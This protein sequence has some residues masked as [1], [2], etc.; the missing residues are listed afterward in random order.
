MHRNL[1][2]EGERG[3]RAWPAEWQEWVWQSWIWLLAGWLASLFSPSCHVGGLITMV[4]YPNLQWWFKTLR[5]VLLLN[6][7]HYFGVFWLLVF[8]ILKISSTS[9]KQPRRTKLWFPNVLSGTLFF[10]IKL[11]SEAQLV[12]R[13]ICTRGWRWSGGWWVCPCRVWTG[14]GHLL[15]HCRLP[16]CL[17]S[18]RGA[19]FPQAFSRFDSLGSCDPGR[20]P[21]S[22]G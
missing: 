3:R 4:L 21:V 8:V 5:I 1:L 16:R 7:F 15:P 11:C 12:N 17:L 19:C 2:L 13:Y 14:T 6:S 22:P 18:S 9:Q 10:Q 20:M